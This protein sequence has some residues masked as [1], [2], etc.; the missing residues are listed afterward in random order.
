MATPAL[1]TTPPEELPMPPRPAR[2]VGL[3]A[4][5]LQ[6]WGRASRPAGLDGLRGLAWIRSM[7]EAMAYNAVHPGLIE[8]AMLR[9]ITDVVGD[10]DVLRSQVPAGRFAAA[11]DVARMVLF[12]ASDESAYCTGAEFV[13]DGGMTA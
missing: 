3:L 12:L 8:T 1:A 11:D 5:V 13:V 2:R 10:D 6:E 7:R 4:A 9:Q